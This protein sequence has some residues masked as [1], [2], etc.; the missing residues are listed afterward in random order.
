MK[1]TWWKSLHKFS[2]GNLNN[3]REE[4]FGQEKQSYTS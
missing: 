1:I 4:E 2:K 3:A